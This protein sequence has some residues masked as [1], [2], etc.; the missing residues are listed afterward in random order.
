[1]ATIIPPPS[2]V[3]TTGTIRVLQ[4]RLFHFWRGAW[5]AELDIDPSSPSLVPSGKAVLTL[6]GISLSGT[7]DPRGTGSFNS[8]A[9]VRLVAGAGGWDQVVSSQDFVSDLGV[10]NSLLF[11]TTGAL[12]GEVVVTQIPTN[13]EIN[14]PRSAGPA[15]RI[16]TGI[17]WW[18]DLTG[19]TNVGTRLP[20]IQPTDLVIQDWDPIQEKITFSSDSI[21]IPGTVLVDPRFNGA[22]PVVRDV[23]QTFSKTGSHGWAWCSDQ[24]VSRAV[25]AFQAAVQEAVGLANLKHYRYQLT[26]YQGTRMALKS[27]NSGD[28]M[29]DLI[30]VY[31][32]G[33]L[34]G[35]SQVLTS[36]QEVLVAFDHSTEPPTPR[37]VSYNQNGSPV[38]TTIDAVTLNLGQSDTQQINMSG[39]NIAIGGP[40]AQIVMANGNIP[41]ALASAI[42]TF[43]TALQT[44]SAAVAGALSSAGVPIVAAQA[45]LV[46]ALATATSNTPST[47]VQAK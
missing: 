42:L 19:I 14:I 10:P 31:P 46:A 22:A 23:E 40:I 24:G 36:G 1:M 27:V 17:D 21:L 11:T 26:S 33:G 32:W 18:V 6:G 28:G 41:I 3:G 20:A 34:A 39:L 43:Y 2:L 5:I 4:A 47:A 8:K 44:W 30:P 9:S 38:S 25:A 15:S 12:V 13:L 45:A 35:L 16:F 29:P 37:V 7:I